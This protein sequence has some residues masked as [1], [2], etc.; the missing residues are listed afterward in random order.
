[1]ARA[2]SLLNVENNY[3]SISLHTPAEAMT[4]EIRLTIYHLTINELGNVSGA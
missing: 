4:C 1:M 3:A 2:L